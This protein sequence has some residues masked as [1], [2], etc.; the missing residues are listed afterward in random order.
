M[1]WEIVWYDFFVIVKANDINVLVS[2]NGNFDISHRRMGSIQIHDYLKMLNSKL[3]RV[4]KFF[5]FHDLYVYI[6]MCIYMN[7]TFLN[8]NLHV[9]IFGRRW[10]CN[11]LYKKS[12]EIKLLHYYLLLWYI[13]QF[14]LST[15]I[16]TLVQVAFFAVVFIVMSVLY[17][18]RVCVR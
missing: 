8:W 7:E 6:I 12:V 1:E 17:C 10:P 5:Y 11:W 15:T 3:T 14:L 16:L 2:I 9:S 4:K 13:I 18:T